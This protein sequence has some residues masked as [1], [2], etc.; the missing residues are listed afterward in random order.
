MSSGEA[1]DHALRR[2]KAASHHIGKALRKGHFDFNGGVEHQEI[3]DSKQKAASSQQQV[4]SAKDDGRADA[5]Q[6]MRTSGEIFDIA[7]RLFSIGH[8]AHTAFKNT[9]PNLGEANFAVVIDGVG[10]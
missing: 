6:A 4:H 9:L 2:R 7:G 3:T 1:T 8:D 5:N 10:T